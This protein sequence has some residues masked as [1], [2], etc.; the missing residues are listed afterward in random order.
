MAPVFV[1]DSLK[2]SRYWKFFAVDR[3]VTEPEDLFVVFKKVWTP[4]A[5]VF[6]VRFFFRGYVVIFEVFFDV[7]S[8]IHC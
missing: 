8:L 4:D 3:Y 5:G 7:L 2:R 1:S 6:G